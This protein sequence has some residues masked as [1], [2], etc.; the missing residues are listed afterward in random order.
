MPRPRVHLPAHVALRFSAARP[1]IPRGGTF[2]R[3]E[4]SLRPRAFV[5]NS[6][7][8]K[9]VLTGVALWRLRQDSDP[10]LRRLARGA[11]D[12]LRGFLEIRFGSLIDV[13]ELAGIKVGEREP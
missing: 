12:A 5:S 7:A 10:H 8:W 6:L 4:E 13:H 9:I 2:C 1:V 3:V 11:I